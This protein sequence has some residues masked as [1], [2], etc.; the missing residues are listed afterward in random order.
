MMS[1]TTSI[2]TDS[3][4]SDYC[5]LLFDDVLSGN[6]KET[7]FFELFP[8]GIVAHNVPT[9]LVTSQ[10]NQFSSI[11]I[12]FV[13]SA[14]RIMPSYVGANVSIS[15]EN[16]GNAM[17]ASCGNSLQISERTCSQLSL[18]FWPE[19]NIGI[20][21]A[22]EAAAIFF[23]YSLAA[24][25]K[26]DGSCILKFTVHSILNSSQYITTNSTILL[27]A[28]SLKSSNISLV[29]TGVPISFQLEWHD[30]GQKLNSLSSS[31]VLISL[32][33]CGNA[34]L[35]CGSSTHLS[36]A[37][38]MANSSSGSS[39]VTGF[40]IR[41]DATLNCRL[42]FTILEYMEQVFTHQD[43]EVRASRLTVDHFP[44]IVRV[45]NPYSFIS[46]ARDDNFARLQSLYGVT[47]KF[48]LELCGLASFDSC[49]IRIHS[50]S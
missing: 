7:S 49:G 29:T 24:D 11:L 44:S 2:D 30:A 36:G 5:R 20:T 1:F 41:G 22:V 26:I 37:S 19:E 47:M 31:R 25:A 8:S 50:K 13:D 3:I 10:F 40:I 38:C 4:V 15:I 12:K 6:S 48:K 35:D 45:G 34:N 43:F 28:S 33:Y 14:S 39:M 23:N 21:D 9:S 46:S 42:T 17:F 32:S 27:Y 16:C 18:P